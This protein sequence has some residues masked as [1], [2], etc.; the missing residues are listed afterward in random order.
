[1]PAAD[2]AAYCLYALTAASAT[3]SAMPSTGRP[4]YVGQPA[5]DS[6]TA[7]ARASQEPP[8]GAVGA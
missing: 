4:P 7:V 8:R 5:R 2:L 6:L 3:P 1:M